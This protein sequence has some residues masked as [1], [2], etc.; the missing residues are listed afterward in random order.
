MVAF[1]T[2]HRGVEQRGTQAQWPQPEDVQ[3]SINSD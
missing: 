2:D 1:I 3:E